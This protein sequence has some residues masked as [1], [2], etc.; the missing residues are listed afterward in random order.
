MDTRS[1]I[2]AVVQEYW[3][4]PLERLRVVQKLEDLR[5]ADIHAGV[6]FVYAA[7]SGPARMAL[8]QVMRLLSTLDL[9]T[10]DVV[11]LDIDCLTAEDTQRL[12][13]HVFGGYGETLWI[14]E[15]R[16]VA[17]VL[18]HTDATERMV[19]GWTQELL[20]DRSGD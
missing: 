11:I 15:G 17:K 18:V 1:D 14:R 13:G 2:R 3:A 9:G 8:G 16:V 19:L 20:K 10:L 4:L 6:V 7:W 5:L 12:F